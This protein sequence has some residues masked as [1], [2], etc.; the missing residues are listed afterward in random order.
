[1]LSI[2]NAGA[3]DIPPIRELAMQVWPQTYTPILGPEQ[4]AYM[5]ALFYTPA[6]LEKQ[7]AEPEHQFI[8]CY[9]DNEP[10]AFAAWS[11]IAPHIFKLHKIYIIPGQQGKGI[12]R[13]IIDHIVREIRTQGATTLLLNVNIYNHAAKAFY[14]K[15]GF[16]HL[17]DEDIDIGSGYFMNDHVLKLD[18][19]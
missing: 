13:F 15:T 12:G 17:R 8:I 18:V 9:N 10:V 6:S 16:K 19:T 1:M 4:V 11:P 14:A 2:K 7:M 3:S 5:L